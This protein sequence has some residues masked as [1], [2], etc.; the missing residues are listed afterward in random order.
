MRVGGRD[1]RLGGT[2]RERFVGLVGTERNRVLGLGGTDMERV[3]GLGGTDMERV[4]GLG[5][6]DM[7]RA[8][9]LGGTLREREDRGMLWNVHSKSSYY[10]SLIT[11]T[12][13]FLFLS[14]ISSF[15]L[16]FSSTILLP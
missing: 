13:F 16:G 6:T 8:L 11:E 15:Y 5:E 14:G 4:A 9:G 2:N 3:E 10:C 7:E 1:D 12:Y